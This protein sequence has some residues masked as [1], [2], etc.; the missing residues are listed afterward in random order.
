[1]NHYPYI[2]GDEIDYMENAL[3]ISAA[4]A[5]LHRL[6]FRTL[7]VYCPVPRFV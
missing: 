5:D 3:Y 7:A 6:G 4:E 2:Y 1:M